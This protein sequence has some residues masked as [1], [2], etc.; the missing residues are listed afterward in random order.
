MSRNILMQKAVEGNYD[1]LIMID[2][3]E[4]P[5]SDDVF[6]RLVSA[7]KDMVSGV[8]RLRVKQE[9]LNILH[10]EDYTE[11]DMAGMKKYVCYQDIPQRGLFK[12]DNAGS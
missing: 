10:A 7:G 9:N 1:Y 11:G 5:M 8:V 12:I 2:D 4:Y 6:Y 3:D